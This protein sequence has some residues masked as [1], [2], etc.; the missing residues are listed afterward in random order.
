M[1]AVLQVE[2]IHTYYG[3]SHV[4]QG[5]SLSVERGEVAVRAGV[6]RSTVGSPGTE[7]E[8]AL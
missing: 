6:G 2:D 3:A 4:L 7:L 1:T 5:M 8:F